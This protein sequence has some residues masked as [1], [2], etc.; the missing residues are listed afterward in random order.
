MLST[1]I[2]TIITINFGFVTLLIV[3]LINKNATIRLLESINKQQWEI[4]NDIVDDFKEIKEQITES[5]EKCTEI[6]NQVDRKSS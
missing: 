5:V 6:V 4:I 1:I 2:A 3:Q